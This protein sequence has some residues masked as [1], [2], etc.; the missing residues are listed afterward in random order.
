MEHGSTEH[1]WL[2]QALER[3]N[4]Q[5]LGTEEVGK[6][7]G[8]TCSEILVSQTAQVATPS[9]EIAPHPGDHELV[10]EFEDIFL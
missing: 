3:E 9:R 2:S 1:R 7:R 6:M 5:A 4:G 10:L 8:R